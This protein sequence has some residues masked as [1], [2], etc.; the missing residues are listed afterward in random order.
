MVKKSNAPLLIIVDD[1]PIFR[2]GLVALF[3]TLDLEQDVCA[4]SD[5]EQAVLLL[6]SLTAKAL[7]NSLLVL[8]FGLPGLSGL[9]ALSHVKSHFPDLSVMVVSGSDEFIQVSACIEAGAKGFIS[10]SAPPELVT[11]TI[12]QALAKQLIKP[13]WL[14]TTGYANLSQLPKTRLT[15]RQIDVLGLISKG[16]SNRELAHELGIAEATAKIHVAAIFKELNV[17]NRTQA[18]IAARKLGFVVND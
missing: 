12:A 8:D 11:E 15:S 13:V 17:I 9:S 18:L 14:T 2:S 4:C 5:Y 3:E 1:H 6:E 7:Q 10:K 16:L